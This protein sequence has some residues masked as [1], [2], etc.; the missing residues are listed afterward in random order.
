MAEAVEEPCSVVLRPV[1]VGVVQGLDDGVSEHVEGETG[2]V[3]QR[4][5]DRSNQVVVQ[6]NLRQNLEQEALGQKR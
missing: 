4:V 6:L 5:D 3:A 1:L 2:Q